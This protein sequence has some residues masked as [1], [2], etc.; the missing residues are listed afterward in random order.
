[1]A[2]IFRKIRVFGRKIRLPKRVTLQ[3]GR[4]RE[5]RSPGEYRSVLYARAGL[6]HALR[7]VAISSDYENYAMVN[8]DLRLTFA[9]IQLGAGRLS[10]AALYLLKT[11]LKDCYGTLPHDTLLALARYL[12]VRN[13]CPAF[14]SVFSRL[15]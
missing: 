3:R 2:W 13:F 9:E 7:Q 15:H 8:L 11:D 6:Q 10:R 12:D 5:S 4:Y 14:W 1:L